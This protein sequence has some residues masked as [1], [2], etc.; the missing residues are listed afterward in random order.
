MTDRVLQ[1]TPP[2]ED[3]YGLAWSPDGSV[4]AAASHQRKISLWRWPDRALVQTLEYAGSAHLRGLRE[5]R[6]G[7][8]GRRFR[9]RAPLLG[10]SGIAVSP[11]R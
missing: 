2:H 5:G 6:Q 9:R 7:P 1:I 8:G 4:L 3:T 10:P 11:R